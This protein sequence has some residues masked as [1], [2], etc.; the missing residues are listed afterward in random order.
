M[1]VLEFI[2][3]PNEVLYLD[4]GQIESIKEHN[5][6]SSI[7]YTKTGKTHHVNER[8]CDAMRRW[9]GASEEE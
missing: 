3:L 7:V 9:M 2:T 5:S 4:V 6:V 8:A 1:K